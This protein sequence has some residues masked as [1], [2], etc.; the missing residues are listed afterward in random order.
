MFKHVMKKIN[1][2]LLSQRTVIMFRAVL[3]ALFCGGIFSS[4]AYASVLIEVDDFQA[5]LDAGA[6]VIDIRSPAEVSE[7]GAITG[8]R[9]IPFFDENGYSDGAAWFANLRQQVQPEQALI[10]V[11]QT[12]NSVLPI[13]NILKRKEGYQQVSA[14]RGGFPIWQ[15]QQA[16]LQ[17]AQQ[18]EMEQANSADSEQ[19]LTNPAE[20]ILEGD[21]LNSD[22]ITKSE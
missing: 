18:L 15:K 20:S 16:A 19:A 14:L 8:S 9:A 22:T 21:A 7:Y 11:D 13:C 3:L 1:P 2:C 4:N 10:L 17:A 12:G 5:Q 6:I